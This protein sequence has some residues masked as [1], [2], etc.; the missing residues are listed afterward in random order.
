MCLNY[1]RASLLLCKPEL[2]AAIQNLELGRHESA[3][4]F[5]SGCLR[6][7]KF[8][9]KNNF[10]ALTLTTA[11]LLFT[12]LVQAQFIPFAF[13][14][15]KGISCPTNYVSVPKNLSYVSS[16][17]CVMKYEAKA[18]TN[19]G[20]SYDSDGLSV[21]LGSYKP[22][23]VATNLPWRS[24]NRI[25]ARSECQSLGFGYDLISNAQWQTIARNVVRS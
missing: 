2:K 5:L 21:S 16:D 13:W 25:N 10:V 20:G 8:F 15:K 6:S 17:F 19:A 9:L 3:A 23:S 12:S 7:F 18:E 24:I 14:N 11:I 22:A 1:V 4:K